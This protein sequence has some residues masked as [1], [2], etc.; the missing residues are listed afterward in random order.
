MHREAYFG[1]GLFEEKLDMES[2]RMEMCPTKVKN[3][4]PQFYSQ[5]KESLTL[6]LNVL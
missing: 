6:L 1:F 2:C 3:C 5:T 4:F